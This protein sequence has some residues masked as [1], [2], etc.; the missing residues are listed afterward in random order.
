MRWVSTIERMESLDD[1]AR[2]VQKA[3]SRTVPQQ[4]VR[5]DLLSGTWLGR[6][7]HPVLTDVVIGTWV[8]AFLLDVLADERAEKAADQ[9]LSIGNLSALAT[10]AAG[11]SD[12]ADLWGEDQ[13][14]GSIHAVGNVT[15]FCLQVV[16]SKARRQGRRKAAKL[17]SLGAVGIAGCAAYLGGHLSFMKGVGVNQTAFEAWPQE[18]TPVIDDVD[19]VEGKLVPAKVNDLRVML[20][21]QGEEI[22][23]LSDRCSRRGCPLHLGQVR[24]L[25]IECPCHGSIFRLSDG[26]VIRGPATAPAPAYQ[27]GLSGGKVQIRRPVPTQWTRKPTV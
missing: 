27:V 20:Y 15:A 2:A 4:S 3:V 22:Y 23:A 14:V 13:R 17:L 8:S 24:D 10:V 6:P 25:A 9:L 19:L 5:K 7:L 16:S 26:A 18:W 21:R 12:W 1:I 11:L